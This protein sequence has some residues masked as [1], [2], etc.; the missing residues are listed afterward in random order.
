[1]PD[2]YRLEYFFNELLI[3]ITS[4]LRESSLKTRGFSTI[5]KR[6]DKGKRSQE[7]K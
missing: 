7:A 4:F 5:K 1:V 6:L 3:E 2:P